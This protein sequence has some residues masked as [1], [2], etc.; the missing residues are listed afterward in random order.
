MARKG[1]V[2]GREKTFATA[3]AVTN[4]VAYS[5]TKAG[6]R[7]PASNGYEVARRPAVQA[8]IA[9]Q[10]L[11]AL[12]EIGLPLA[13]RTHIALLQDPKCPPGAKVQAVKLMYDRT[14]G[15]ENQGDR[16]EPHE[17]TADELAREIERMKREVSDRA[18]TVILDVE[19]SEDTDLFG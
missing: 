18:R 17:M 16:K 13:V 1:V 2:T 15:V 5:A 14:L 12:F 19:P 6:Y 7:S 11:A 8:E 9:A 3:M 10:Q 4:D